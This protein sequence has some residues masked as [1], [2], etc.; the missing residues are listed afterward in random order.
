MINGQSMQ[1]RGRV[2]IVKI[3]FPLASLSL[4]PKVL[5]TILIFGL[6]TSSSVRC[7][8]GIVDQINP[9]WLVISKESNEQIEI[10]LAE[11][12]TLIKEGDWVIYW[13]QQKRLERLDS[14]GSRMESKHHQHLIDLL[15]QHD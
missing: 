6:S 12:E 1:V 8:I 7:W 14:P 13:T 4:I 2:K 9:P 3:Y 15:I 11:G 10:P 5:S